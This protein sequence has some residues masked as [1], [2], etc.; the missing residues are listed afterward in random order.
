MPPLRCVPVYT[1]CPFPT[2]ISGSSRSKDRPDPLVY[3]EH[4]HGRNAGC[5]TP[6]VQSRTCS[7]PASGS[8]VARA[9][10]QGRTVLSSRPCV[11]WTAGR[12]APAA[13][14][15]HVLDACPVQAACFRRVLPPVVGFPHL[16]VRRSIRLPRRIRRAFPVTVLLRLPATIVHR[17]AE[18]PAWFRVR[19]APAVPQE[20]ET[21]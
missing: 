8:S 12:L 11:L 14:F 7:V 19:V 5:P 9:S 18:V 3:F 6:P 17:G 4:R 10:A 21:I 16:G 20:L 15:R 13:P 1:I 2:R